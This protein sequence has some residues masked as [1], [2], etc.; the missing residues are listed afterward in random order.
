MLDSQKPSARFCIR[1]GTGLVV[2]EEDGKER[3]QC[4]A[5]GWVYYPKPNIASAVAILEDGKVLLVRRKHEP[6]AGKWT[7]PSGFMEF[8]EDPKETAV[9]E[10]QEELAVEVEVTGLIDVLMERGD[11]RGLCLVV[12]YTGRITSGET[13]PG[14]DASEVRA[15]SLDALPDDFAWKAHRQA[16]EELR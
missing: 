12:F 1:C 5:C 16:L 3:Q 11:P 6:F 15:F 13:K 2:R 14:D 9:R 10:L 7:L 8:G 4:P